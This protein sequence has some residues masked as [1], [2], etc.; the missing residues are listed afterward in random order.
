MTDLH[1]G[2][3]RFIDP[4]PGLHG[5]R[6]R[7]DL[8][9]DSERP[10][11]TQQA[12]PP[13]APNPYHPAPRQR[14]G[15]QESS[16]DSLF[17][18]FWPEQGLPGSAAAVL[19]ALGA[20]ILAGI[21]LP[22]RDHGIGTF[23]VLLACGAAVLGVAV[24][25]RSAFTLACS[26]LSVLLASTLVLRDAEWIVFLCVVAAAAVFVIGVVDGRTVQGFLLSGIAWG[27][28]PLRGLPWLGRS[29]RPV[30]RLGRSGAAVRTALLSLLGVAVF[31]LLFAS[32]DAL[33]AEWADVVVP[34]L[35]IDTFVFRAF[36]AAFVSGVVVSA[37]YL[38]VNPPKVDPAG[39]PT[40]PVAQRY[41]WLVPVLLVDAVF[42]VFIGAQATV[43]FGGH[44]YLER[45]TGLTYA[46]YVHQ[47][48]G[49]LTV[50]TGLTLLVVWAAARKAPRETT[51]DVLWVRASLG[52][53]C[54]L[55]LVVVASALYRMHV[56]QE[57]YGFTELR[58]LVDVF[59]GWLGV[60][61]VA[62]MAAGITLRGSWLPRA[63]VLSGAGALLGLA[64]INPDAWIAEHNLDRYAETGNID[65]AYITGLS[66]DMVPAL[67]GQPADVVT[68]SLMGRTKI[69]DDWL[70]W[71]LGR[72]RAESLVSEHL[73]GRG[74]DE[75]ACLSTD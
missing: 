24:H 52:L 32:A 49:Q 50:A 59:E 14:V 51:S 35:K 45:T 4:D 63:A 36:L 57:A 39:A 18:G 9:H 58:L 6:V 21:V 40:R 25:R 65:W 10:V 12:P 1:A 56:Y 67:E 53:L 47:G 60:L 2:S 13:P 11:M 8:P 73:E 3:I 15:P 43:F 22:F 26:A 41:E 28:A 42:L 68:C 27:L 17:G 71:N 66:T 55:T 48:F 62:V 72:S 33:F 19:G 38:A 34:D 64:L 70:E 69:D 75:P 23:V 20:G 16:T 5:A 30:A 37:A 46:E 74:I 44:D 61:V 7:V 31:G 54:A 29:L